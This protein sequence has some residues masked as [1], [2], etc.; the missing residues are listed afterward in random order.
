MNVFNSDN[1]KVT[2]DNEQD[3]WKKLVS[4]GVDAQKI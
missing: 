3:G 2:N 4:C 1:F